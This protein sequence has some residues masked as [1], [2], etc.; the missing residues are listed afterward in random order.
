M[1]SL[2]ILFL[3]IIVFGQRDSLLDKHYKDRGY[4]VLS[5]STYIQQPSTVNND[6]INS[7]PSDV[8]IQSLNGSKLTLKNDE[9]KRVEDSIKQDAMK[10]SYAD[11]K[12]IENEVVNRV[13]GGIK[14]DKVDLVE[15]ENVDNKKSY[16]TDSN[17]KYLLY[18]IIAFLIFILGYLQFRK[19]NKLND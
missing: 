11:K 6:Y 7:L 10:L 2:L 3:P 4:V 5:T 19:K 15:Y 8:K 1:K 18:A 17:E 12:K 13:L 14:E 9:R 16:S